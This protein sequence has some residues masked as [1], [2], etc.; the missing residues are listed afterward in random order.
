[1][2][3]LATMGSMVLAGLAGVFGVLVQPHVDIAPGDGVQLTVLGLAAALVGGTSAFGRRGGI[4]GTV[5]AAI[6]LAIIVE[7]VGQTQLHWSA[8]A[9]AAVGIGVGLVVTRLVERFGR[10]VL[11]PA[12][13]DEDSWMPRVHSL[14]PPARP[15]EPGATPTGGLW[16]DEGWG[17]PP[18]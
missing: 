13:G 12:S 18:R 16:T 11:V 15:W 10:P 6:L 4:F 2:A 7:L 3:V 5:F 8:M 14:A 1:M 9:I 17:N